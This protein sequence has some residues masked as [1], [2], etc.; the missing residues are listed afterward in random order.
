MGTRQQNITKH[1][2]ARQAG[3]SLPSAA[4]SQLWTTSFSQPYSADD[5]TLQVFG[6]N[7]NDDKD[8]LL[9]VIV[10]FHGGLFNCGLVEDAHA[11][12]QVLASDAVVVCVDYPLAP[13]LHFPNTV[14]VAFEAVQWVWKHAPD[15]G[16]DRARITVAG[17]QAG[18]NLAA[19]VAM[20]ARDRSSLPGCNA[21]LQGQVLIN[22][23]L[24]S[25]QTTKSMVA[26]EDCP[27]RKAW[28]DYV[29]LASDAMH[30]YASPVNSMRLG[31]LAPALIITGELEPLRD[32]AEQYATK[33]IA[34]G[35]PVKM[36]R[37]QGVGGNLVD[38]AHPSFG[39]V[40]QT[41][42]QFI[43]DAA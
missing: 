25:Q 5:I 39:V 30:P 24:D 20:M 27:C 10:Y 22:P 7:S 35:V 26:A 38:A 34:A 11:V 28:V 36:R 43:A 1:A 31:G 40:T 6:K 21:R 37:L 42:A 18:G 17:D 4:Q 3:K 9:P 16:A 12:A 19:A 2:A 29:P 15:I 23:L 33:L 14:E 13:Q 41:V 32:E 8:A